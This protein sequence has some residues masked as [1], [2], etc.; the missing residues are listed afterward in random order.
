[1]AQVICSFCGRV[2]K[3]VELMI[4]GIQAHICDKCII[5]AQ[6]ILN[7]EKKTKDNPDAPKF[8]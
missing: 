5:Q 6:Q 8:K 4:S 2:K 1:M 7:E 3:D